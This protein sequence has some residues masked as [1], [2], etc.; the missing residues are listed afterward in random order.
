MKRKIIALAFGVALLAGCS[1]EPLVYTNVGT[2]VGESYAFE[3][4]V[5]D[6]REIPCVWIKQGLS[7]DWS[8]Q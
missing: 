2:V 7:C 4:K 5:T 3:V 6:G 1:S 8:K